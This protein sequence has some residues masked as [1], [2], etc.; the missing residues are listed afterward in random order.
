[1]P[2]RYLRPLLR[3]DLSACADRKQAAIR[4]RR[5]R[6][7]ESAGKA[8]L[9]DRASTPGLPR[10]RPNMVDS[11]LS[12][13]APVRDWLAAQAGEWRPAVARRL[14]RVSQS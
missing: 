5:G 4:G 2:P 12:A 1:M 14:Q 8:R 9:R 3:S 10:D 13:C 11:A 7:A 6:R